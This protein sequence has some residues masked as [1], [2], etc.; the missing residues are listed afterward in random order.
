MYNAHSEY[1][2]KME[3]LVLAITA[4]VLENFRS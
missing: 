4:A 1:L 3:I 2:L